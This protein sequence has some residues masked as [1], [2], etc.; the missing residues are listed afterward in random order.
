MATNFKP[1]NP[2]VND[3]S[4]GVLKLP[5]AVTTVS[6]RAKVADQL[7]ADHHLNSG[8]RLAPSE[9]KRSNYHVL[10][11]NTANDGAEN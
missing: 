1:T 7:V 8:N 10:F 9:A 11:H 6:I 2:A 5:S 3:V 4:D